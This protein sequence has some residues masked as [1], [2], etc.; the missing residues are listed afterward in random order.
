MVQY[1]VETTEMRNWLRSLVKMKKVD[2]CL[3]PYL[4]ATRKKK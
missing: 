2:P 3:F 4:V 1:G